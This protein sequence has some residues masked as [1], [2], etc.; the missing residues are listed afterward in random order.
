LSGRHVIKPPRLAPGD[1]I[2]IISPASP[3]SSECPERF[4][5]GVAHLEGMGFT[6]RVARHAWAR[7]GHTAGTIEQRIEDIHSLFSDPAVR[8]VLTSVG[9]LNSNQLLDGLDYDLIA[10][11]PKILMG[12][13][14]ATALL[15]AI[16][17]R[18][19]LVTFLGPA[20][21]P[22]FGE[23]G[24]LHA[25]TARWFHRILMQGE[26][27]L[28]LTPSRRCID[29][30]VCRDGEGAM[31][32][33]GRPHRGPRTLVPGSAEGPIVAGNLS[34]LLV[35]ACSPYWP[36]LD[37]AILCVEEDEGESPASLDR[38]FTQ[39]R[40]MGVFERIGALLIGRF[41]RGI[42]FGRRDSLKQVLLTAMRGYRLP[43]AVDFDLGHTDPM[44][45]LP[46]GI[47]ARVELDAAPRLTLLEPAVADRTEQPTGASS[48]RTG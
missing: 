43:V 1:T 42:G 34:T 6:V 16:G 5:R 38:M 36:D 2:G 33:R 3:I 8:A 32:R 21:L 19:G 24:G 39:L 47:R 46:N 9:G 4:V 11:N 22:Q 48:T 15:L 25:Y 44:F 35:L 29:E 23:P 40:T 20:V 17:R 27:P 7:H 45:I 14:D 41:P 37:G 30:P 18:S 28:E 10:R 26:A 13:S 12:Y 31:P